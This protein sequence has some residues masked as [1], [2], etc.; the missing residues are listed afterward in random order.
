[1]T[2]RDSAGKWVK[3][4]ASPNPGGRPKELGDV[5]EL[6]KAHSAAAIETLAE[7]MRDKDAPPAARTAAATALLDR[8]FGRPAQSV[9]GRVEVQHSVSDAA[10]EVLRGLAERAKQRR[11]AEDAQMIDVTP[12][13]VV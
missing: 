8:G 11:V 10:A 1:M 2:E 7:I 12:S 13:R 5:R 4:S 6:A 9:E 3:G